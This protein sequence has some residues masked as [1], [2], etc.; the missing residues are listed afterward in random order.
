MLLNTE[1]EATTENLSMALSATEVHSLAQ[2]INLENGNIYVS[3]PEA[4]FGEVYVSPNKKAFGQDVSRND[5]LS[6]VLID[7]LKSKGIDV[8]LL[9]EE[10]IAEKLEELGYDVALQAK[11]KR[12]IFNYNLTP[13]EIEAI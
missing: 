2:I 3:F 10:E 9:S 11:R 12:K 6:Q 8:E 1:I 13:S 7:K 4:T 5:S